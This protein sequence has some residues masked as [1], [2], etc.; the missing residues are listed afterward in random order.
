MRVKHPSSRSAQLNTIFCAY[1][2]IQIIWHDRGKGTTSSRYIEH[3]FD[4][5]KESHLQAVSVSIAGQG[6]QK[7]GAVVVGDRGR[8][9]RCWLPPARTRTSAD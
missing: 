9:S 3:V 1:F 4:F 7:D 6:V 5:E 2:E 8:D